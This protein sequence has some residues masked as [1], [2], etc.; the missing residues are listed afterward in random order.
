MTLRL[1]HRLELNNMK[2]NTTNLIFSFIVLV[3]IQTACNKP[4]LK[5]QQDKVTTIIKTNDSNLSQE[6]S[7]C[8]T[9]KKAKL[10]PIIT[11]IVETSPKF[12][13]YTNGLKKAIIENGGIDWKLEFEESRFQDK[14]YLEKYSF[15]LYELYDDRTPRIASF[16][17]DTKKQKLYEEQ[18]TDS[19]ETP[20]GTLISINFDKKLL[21]ALK[22]L[23]H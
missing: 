6:D 1:A 14:D 19:K 9:S 15:N 10:L 11:K 5:R 20:A 22:R 23:S 2:L 13:H 18:I 21:L 16:C 12:K 3:I 8:L 17:F 4:T 7:L